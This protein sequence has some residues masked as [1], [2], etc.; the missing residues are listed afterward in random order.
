MTCSIIIEGKYKEDLQRRVKGVNYENL[1][2]DISDEE[3]CA[4]AINVLTGF[5]AAWYTIP[6]NLMIFAPI[7]ICQV[8]LLSLYLAAGHG[9]A[10][11]P[12]GC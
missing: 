8:G 3:H 1:Q 12:L 4:V 2:P 10:Q 6:C 9:A 7:T 11:P 5:T